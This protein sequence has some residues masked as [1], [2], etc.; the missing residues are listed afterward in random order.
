[1][2]HSLPPSD[3]YLSRRERN[4]DGRNDSMKWFVS[5]I[6]GVSPSSA[7]RKMRHLRFSMNILRKMRATRPSRQSKGPRNESQGSYLM[8]MKSMWSPREPNLCVVNR[9]MP[10]WLGIFPRSHSIGFIS[11]TII[12]VRFLSRNERSAEISESRF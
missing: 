11:R 2:K 4:T 6:G 8:D 10:G 9:P 5:M 3:R 7:S 12:R 1:M